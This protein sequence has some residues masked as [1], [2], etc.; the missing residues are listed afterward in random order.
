MDLCLAVDQDQ[1]I[2]AQQSESTLATCWEQRNIDQPVTYLSDEDVLM[3]K[4]SVVFRRQCEVV[5]HVAVLKELCFQMF[6]LA[7]DHSL[8]CHLGITVKYNQVF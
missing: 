7:N 4:W 3:R 5:S 6:N 2:K 1:F 8:S